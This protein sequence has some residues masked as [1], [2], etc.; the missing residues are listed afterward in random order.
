VIV[1]W[2]YVL[3]LFLFGCF[4]NHVRLE[5]FGSSLLVPESTKSEFIDFVFFH[6]AGCM[7]KQLPR[8]DRKIYDPDRYKTWIDR[9]LTPYE[10]RGKFAFEYPPYVI[11]LFVPLGGMPLIQAYRFWTG[12]SAFIVALSMILLLSRYVSSYMMKA[13]FFVSAYV[14][15]PGIT[16][17]ATGQTDAFLFLGIACFWLLMKYK[18]FLAAGLATSVVLIKP[19]FAA[20]LVLIGAQLGSR[21]YIIGLAA[22]LVFLMGVSVLCVG[23]ESVLAYPQIVFSA[24]SHSDAFMRLVLYKMENVRGMLIYL[25]GHDSAINLAISVLSLFAVATGLFILWH[26]QYPNGGR[27]DP[28]KTPVFELCAGLTTLATIM[29]STHAYACCY[30]ATTV[31]FVFIWHWIEGIPSA[32]WTRS[33]LIVLILAFPIAGWV[34]VFVF[35]SGYTM[36][37]SMPLEFV[38]CLVIFGLGLVELREY[39]LRSRLEKEKGSQAV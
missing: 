20:I 11:P 15:L 26:K 31:A 13:F 9:S 7:S 5:R 34:R 38:W 29:V 4:V 30:I 21:S 18:R 19:Q 6:A 14:S 2:F 33:V 28:D 16:N 39:S 32:A 12:L 10:S 1:G 25:T 37:P 35:G 24:E 27:F 8:S 17:F 23:W 36:E 3:L 22:S